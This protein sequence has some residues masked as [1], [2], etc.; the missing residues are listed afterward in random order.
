[1]SRMISHDL[2]VLGLMA[3]NIVCLYLWQQAKDIQHG[4]QFNKV[5]VLSPFIKNDIFSAYI[6]INEEIDVFTAC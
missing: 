1:M 2:A 4:F 6:A 5:F 3:K